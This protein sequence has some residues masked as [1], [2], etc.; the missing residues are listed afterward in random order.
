MNWGYE[1][2]CRNSLTTPSV[3]WSNDSALERLLNRSYTLT[4]RVNI[5]KCIKVAT[6]DTATPNLHIY[7]DDDWFD[8]SQCLLE[9]WLAWLRKVLLTK[10]IDVHI[11]ASEEGAQK[12]TNSSKYH[13][14]YQSQDVHLDWFNHLES[15]DNLN[16][17]GAPY[18]YWNWS[19]LVI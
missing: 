9:R 8:D 10:S 17:S 4:N 12:T 7:H 1:I 18:Y 16:S 5:L 3:Y 6:E 19:A 11:Q 13:W 15:R 14:W 2:A